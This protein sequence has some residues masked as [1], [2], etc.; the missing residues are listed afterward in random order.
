MYGEV[1]NKELGDSGFGYDPLFIPL[2]Y[3]NTLGELNY[4]IKKDLSHRTK[5]LKLAM[6]I[7]KIILK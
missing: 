6:K 7:I 5:A 4:G 2:G 1:I 3:E